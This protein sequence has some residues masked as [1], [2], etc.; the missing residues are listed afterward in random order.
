M[1]DDDDWESAWD[2]GVFL[3]DIP[4]CDSLLDQAAEARLAAEQQP[5]PEKIRK[6]NKEIWDSAYQS[7]FSV[8][9]I[10]C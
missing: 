2:S 4:A 10:F 3:P 6:R 1:A 9:F 8:D 5:D 7:F